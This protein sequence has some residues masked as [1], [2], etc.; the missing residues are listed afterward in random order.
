MLIIAPLQQGLRIEVFITSV[1]V[2]DRDGTMIVKPLVVGGVIVSRVPEMH[3]PGQN[4]DGQF[5]AMR[6]KRRVLFGVSGVSG[7]AQGQ[8][9]R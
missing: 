2:K 3:L 7:V 8:L 6:D 4:R 1:V 9:Q 5:G